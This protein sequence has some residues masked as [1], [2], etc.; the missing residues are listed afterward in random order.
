MISSSD[1]SPLD[2]LSPHPVMLAPMV[3]LTHYAVRR[4]VQHFLPEG[5]RVLW[6]TE[7]LNSRRVPSQHVNETPEINFMDQAWGL[8]PQLLAN[9]EEFIRLSVRRLEAWGAAAIDINMGCPVQKALKHNYG[10]ALMGDPQY[11]Q[12]IVR[13]TV[14]RAS[15]PVSVKLRAGLGK[16][17]FDYLYRFVEGLFSAGA[18]WVTIHPR[19]A[20]QMRKGNADWN[21]IR[22]LKREFHRSGLSPQIIG[23]GDVQCRDDIVQMFEESECDRVM[24][25]RAM[26]AK[27]W[28]I[29]NEPEPDLET[30]G[31]WYGEFLLKVLAEMRAH[32]SWEAGRR[33][34]LF[35]VTY[36]RPWIEF[37][38]FLLGRVQASGDYEQMEAALRKFFAQPQR[39]VKRSTLRA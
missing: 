35:L 5:A 28:L 17:D 34:M 9:E 36:G 29:R 21:L 27:P 14:A 11:A 1:P 13:H 8:C 23:N 37:G 2:R 7:M 16:Q 24:V 6:P 32:Y 22:R 31:A 4:G 12:E 25:G 10:V 38:Q 26:I 30:Q 15:V 20:E 19:T 33:R 3:G 18:S 39:M